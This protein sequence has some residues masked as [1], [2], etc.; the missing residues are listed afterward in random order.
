MRFL[1]ADYPR[2]NQWIMTESC[3]F[4]YKQ[5]RWLV[6]IGKRLFS[7]KLKVWFKYNKDHKEIKKRIDE[8]REGILKRIPQERIKKNLKTYNFGFLEICYF[9]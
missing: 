7:V 6:G 3:R 5:F 9:D 8:S 2:E 4:S 1:L